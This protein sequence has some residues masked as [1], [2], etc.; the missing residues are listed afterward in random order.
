MAKESADDRPLLQRI[1]GAPQ[2]A[3]LVPRLAPE[4]LHRVIQT[5]GLED[6]GEF[7]ALAT[8]EQLSRVF[9]L[10]LW[11]APRPG[12]DEELDPERFGVWLQVLL[13]GGVDLAAEKLSAMD[14]GV[15]AAALAGHVRVFDRAAVARGDAVDC[16]VGP[17]RVEAKRT[18]AWDAIVDLLLH[19]DAQHPDCFHRLMRGCRRLSNAGWEIDGSHDLLSDDEQAMF[20]LAVDRE[21]RRERLGY[22]TPAQ[23]RAFLQMAR[24]HRPEDVPAASGNP[25]T[26]AY[27]RGVRDE[28]AAESASEVE[29]AAMAAL[30]DLLLEAGVTDRPR[31]LLPG[32]QVAAPRLARI[33]AQLQDVR[34]ADPRA[35]LQRTDELAYLANTLLAGCSIQGRAFTLREASEA[36]VAA[37]NLGLER[38]PEAP[39]PDAFLATHD[40]I[41]AFQIGWSA[42]YRDVAMDASGRLI[43][44]LDDLRC[45]DREIQL[46]LDALHARLTAAR[47]GG[48]PWRARQALDVIMILDPPSWAALLGLVDEC[49]VMHAAMDAFDTPRRSI[50]ASEFRFI[51]ETSDIAAVRGFMASLPER[52]GTR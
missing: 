23:A 50:K 13:D 36:A 16:E 35:Y 32:A 31:A 33:Q 19:L 2:I 48:T 26:R 47:G 1:L 17:Y 14:S 22:V 24:E 12:L 52:L 30:G 8:P 43:R 29:P 3:Q 20:D 21:A 25:I 18:D 10:D 28:P 9:D 15:V 44:V 49:P 38:W 4:I 7:V 27:F 11:R 5:C 51:S 40:L 6:C 46:G 39:L 42:L 41:G 45:D 34:D 37:C